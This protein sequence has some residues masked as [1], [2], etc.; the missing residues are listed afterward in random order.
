MSF[1]NF[2]TI[3]LFLFVIVT[4]GAIAAKGVRS[5]SQA[6]PAPP[7]ATNADVVAPA[8]VDNALVAYYFHSDFRCPTCRTIE[9][10]AH[11]A[12]E[13]AFADDLAT[14]AVQWRVLNY[15]HPENAARAEQYQIVAPVVV[16]SKI[17]N[18]AEVSW[19]SLDKVWQLTDDK[20]AFMNYVQDEAR[21]LQ[22]R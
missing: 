4:I 13:T 6:S 21:N 2:I 20:A 14:G 12:V 16:L 10:Y 1:K 5:P 9:S 11:E 7:S 19:V 3:S 15:E 18:G 22:A 8:K 17:E